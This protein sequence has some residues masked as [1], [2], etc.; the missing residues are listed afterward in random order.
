ML[1]SCSV[2]T[3]TLFVSGEQDQLISPDRTQQLIDTFDTSC[4]QKFQ[5]GGGHMV[6]TCTGDFKQTLRD[7]LDKHGSE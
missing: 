6:P 3:P 4:I 7:F 2:K 1:S 5:H